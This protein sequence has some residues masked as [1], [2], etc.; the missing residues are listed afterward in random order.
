MSKSRSEQHLETVDRTISDAAEAGL[1]LLSAED[2]K[3][4]GRT[5]TLHGK[6]YINFGSCSYLGLELDPRI[7]AGVV[8]AVERYGSQ[9]ASSRAFVSAPFYEEIEAL[10]KEMYQAPAILSPTLTLGH[11]A[12]IPVLI[13]EGDAVILDHQVHACMQMA[14]QQLKFRGIPV[15]LIRHSRMDKLETRIKQLKDTHNRIW[16][17]ADG[18]YSMYGDM[19]PIKELKSLL[20]TYEQLRLYIDDAHGCGCMGPNGAG[21]VFR[22][23]PFHPQMYLTGSLAKS[24]ATA[25]GI[26]VYPNEED[27]RRVRASGPTMLFSGPIQPPLLGAILATL[28]IHLSGDLPGLQAQLNRRVHFFNRMAREKDLPLYAESESPVC[29]VQVGTP[30]AGYDMLQK[31]KK[32]GMF[33]NLAVYPGVPYNKTGIRLAIN[34]HLS[35]EDIGRMVEVI[36]KELPDTLKRHKID[37]RKLMQAAQIKIPA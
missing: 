18:V 12:N 24:M 11:Q 16:Y 15:E 4:N 29:C 19:A 34:N 37:M 28:K 17:F 6:E 36:A 21:Y 32:Q 25:G 26:L 2:Y 23:L 35:F 3:A 5:V 14:T 1:M 20:D 9:F 8:D 33:A 7:K 27:R 22:E 13:K 30:A 31:L 10:L